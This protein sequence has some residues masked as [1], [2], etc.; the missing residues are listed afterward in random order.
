MAALVKT[1]PSLVV[2]RP[3]V[4]RMVNVVPRLVEQRAAPAAKACSRDA[5]NM[6][7]K[8]KD[9]PMGRRMPVTATPDER[10]ILAFSDL[11]EVAKPPTLG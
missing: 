7:F 5:L 8:A 11:N 9:K 6:D 10:P 1:T 2:D 3:L 4:P